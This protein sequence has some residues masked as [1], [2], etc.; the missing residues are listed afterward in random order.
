MRPRSRGPRR[1]LLVTALA[2]LVVVLSACG[3]T[4]S[5]EPAI[6]EPAVVEHPRGSDIARITLTSE[7]MEKIQVDSVPVQESGGGTVV[8]SA[9][10]LVDPQ[11][12]FWVYTNPEPRVF[13]RHEIEVDHE[14]AGLAFLLEGPPAGTAVVTVG[15][16][17]L[18]GTEFGVGH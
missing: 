5:D 10:L 4:V 1:S 16:A 3:G 14:E 18:Y 15:V 13:V 9:A 17:E 7:A 6:E 12:R 8:P 11:G 2:P